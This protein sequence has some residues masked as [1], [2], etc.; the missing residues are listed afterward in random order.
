[1]IYVREPTADEITEL[2][3]MARQEVGRVSQRAQ[4]VLLSARHRGVPEIARIFALS[5][6]SVR[7]WL[8][9]FD[10]VGPAGLFDQPRS[11]RPR[12]ASPAVDEAVRQLIQDDPADVGYLATIWTVAMLVL[13]VTKRL[14]VGLSTSAV[15]TALHRLGLRWGRP[16]LAMP[17]KVDPEKARKQWEVALAVIEAGPDAQILYADES[18]VQLLPLLRTMWHWV[19]QQ[20]RIPTPGTNDSRAVFGALNIDTGRWVYQIRRHMHT[21]DFLGFLEYLLEQYP[22]GPILLIID[23]YSSHTAHAVLP[24]LAEH[25]RLRVYYLPKYCS[26]LN[27]VE[28]IWLQLKN[29]IAADRLYASIV[30]LTETVDEFFLKMTP[31]QALTWAAS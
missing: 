20:I 7:F 8:R 17:R 31:E 18:R 24:W 13:A 5:R 1:M 3:R 12:K 16:R 28:P 30:R 26:H 27:P 19:G 4:M 29:T 15:R 9:R 2:K 14:G 22:T 6:A 11:G 21:E 23:N 25:L 10:G